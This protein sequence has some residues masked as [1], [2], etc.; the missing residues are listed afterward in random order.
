M[1]KGYASRANMKWFDI[2]VI[3]SLLV[4]GCGSGGND[5]QNSGGNST[6][7]TIKLAGYVWL[8]QQCEIENE[9]TEYFK[10]LYEFALD[11][12]VNLGRQY[13]EDSDCTVK[14]ERAL[15]VDVD[16]HYAESG[17]V[18]LENGT[19][20]EGISV[21]KAGE[22]VNGYYTISDSSV[23]CFSYNLAFPQN[24]TDE[25]NSTA[26]DYSHC[27]MPEEASELEEDDPMINQ[28]ELIWNYL[29]ESGWPMETTT[30]RPN[31]NI[32]IPNCSFFYANN[33]IGLDSVASTIGITSDNQI[34]GVRDPFVVT[35]I[36]N[37]TPNIDSISA[38][39]WAELFIDFSHGI[40]PG[41]ILLE[42][43]GV[44]VDKFKEAGVDFVPPELRINDRDFIVHFFMDTY[45]TSVAYEITIEVEKGLIHKVDK[46]RVAAFT[47]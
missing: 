18:T 26:I 17:S 10:L 32:D 35:K 9:A 25:S 1:N 47:D 31:N 45:E 24:E 20:G 5:N 13:Y 12:S 23:L 37:V 3:I 21:E 19:R 44:Y 8:P 33:N 30:V 38:S 22:V 11:G 34:I 40:E 41:W 29:K 28:E 39:V 43:E 27:L 15:P 7:Q 2:L 42:L 36:L 16:W 4:T 6:E 46:Q 14:S